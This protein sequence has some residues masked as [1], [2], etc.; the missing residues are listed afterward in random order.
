MI[1]MKHKIKALSLRSL[2]LMQEKLTVCDVVA[3]ECTI[4][5][6]TLSARF[7]DISLRLDFSASRWLSV[8]HHRYCHIQNISKS[9][10]LDTQIGDLSH[11]H[12]ARI[13]ACI[14]NL[15]DFS[16]FSSSFLRLFLWN[17]L[18][19]RQKSQ[20][21]ILRNFHFV[22]TL[23]L[24]HVFEKSCRSWVSLFYL[25]VFSSTTQCLTSLHILERDHESETIT[26]KVSIRIEQASCRNS[27]FITKKKY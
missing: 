22:E 6:S 14:L 11:F 1:L 7:I 24:S 4:R 10:L 23:S 15:C 5:M 13:K 25:R 17:R 27:K 21:L 18:V 12:Y 8:R 16:L 3:L 20:R 19:L 2:L 9:P 26:S